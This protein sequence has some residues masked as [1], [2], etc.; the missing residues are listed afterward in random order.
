[1]IKEKS[2]FTVQN[3][4]KFNSSLIKPEKEH[5]DYSDSVTELTKADRD[6]LVIKYMYLVDKLAKKV[7]TDDITAHD[8]EELKGVGYLALVESSLAYK[9]G[10]KV[11][12]SQFSYDR[13]KSSMLKQLKQRETYSRIEAESL[14]AAE[15]LSDNRYIEA[16]EDIEDYRSILSL[17]NLRLKNRPRGLHVFLMHSGLHRYDGDGVGFKEIGESLNVCMARVAAINSEIVR[18]MKHPYGRKLLRDYGFEFMN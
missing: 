11:P 3:G 5:N 12:F 15:S 14:E 13:I 9:S 4:M 1:M 17:L 7:S 6:N 2:K 8:F 18:L 10:S 16:F